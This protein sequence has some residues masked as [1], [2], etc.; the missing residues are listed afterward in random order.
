VLGAPVQR[1]QDQH[2]ER[3]LQKF[4]AGISFGHML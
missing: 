3:A 4:D 2:V 1:A